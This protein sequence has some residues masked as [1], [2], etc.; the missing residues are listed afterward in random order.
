MGNLSA[1]HAGYTA[2][3]D[4]AEDDCAL[5]EA[6]ENT[7]DDDATPAI[8]LME[9]V[10]KY[11]AN[12]TEREEKTG[13][14][15]EITM[16]AITDHVDNRVRRQMSLSERIKKARVH[17]RMFRNMLNT[18]TKQS[19]NSTMYPYLNHYKVDREKLLRDND[20]WDDL[21]VAKKL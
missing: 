5:E 20:A 6:A 13:S 16:Q 15:H 2:A 18:N 3:E 10:D 14:G 9:L 12:A 17:E 21:N 8:N 4:D 7:I 11:I 19:T 1:G